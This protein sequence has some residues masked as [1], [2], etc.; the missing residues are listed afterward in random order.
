M[1]EENQPQFF[2]NLTM[3][4]FRRVRLD[5][6]KQKSKFNILLTES[7][8]LDTCNNNQLESKHQPLKEK[9]NLKIESIP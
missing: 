4:D 8:S 5:L 3:K 1:E 2:G 6:F 7:D 9:S